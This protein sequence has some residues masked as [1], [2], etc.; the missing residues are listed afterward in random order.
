MKRPEISETHLRCIA[1][2]DLNLGEVTGHSEIFLGMWDRLFQNYFQICIIQNKILLNQRRKLV[3]QNAKAMVCSVAAKS[4]YTHTNAQNSSLE[5]VEA[6]LRFIWIALKIGVCV[7]M[8]ERELHTNIQVVTMRR[9]KIVLCVLCHWYFWIL[10]C[11]IRV[12][13]V[14]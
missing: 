13:F 14:N 5:T 8:Q 7:H 11:W 9:L 1:G 4:F 12:A 2:S 10:L 6:R 3:S